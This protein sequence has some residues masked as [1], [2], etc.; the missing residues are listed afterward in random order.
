VKNFWKTANKNVIL[1][2]DILVILREVIKHKNHKIIIGTDSVK[3]GKAFIF[4]NAI[5]IINDNEYYNRRYFYTRKKI[6]SH[7]FYSLYTRLL[8]ETTDSIEI[9]NFLVENLNN[10]NIEIHADINNNKKYKSAKYKNMI[11]S[12]INA[13]GFCCKI[14]PD[15]FVASGIADAYTRN[16]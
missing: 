4:A 10:P 3:L 15:S 14:K 13:Y 9:A 11:I 1:S 12:Y 7:Q 16:S 6:N 2:K 5:C 8:K